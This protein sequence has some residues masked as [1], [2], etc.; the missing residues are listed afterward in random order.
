MKDKWFRW[1]KTTGTSQ[2]CTKPVETVSTSLVVYNAVTCSCSFVLHR[3]LHLK[4]LKPPN[5]SKTAMGALNS[6]IFQF[7]FWRVNYFLKNSCSNNWRQ[8]PIPI[9]WKKISRIRFPTYRLGL[10]D[11]QLFPWERPNHLLLPFASC[12]PISFLWPCF[13]HL[14]LRLFESKFQWVSISKKSAD[15]FLCFRNGLHL[16]CSWCPLTLTLLEEALF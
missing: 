2:W 13:L 3:T 6:E 4:I 12:M 10:R 8:S 5:V 11:L 16:Y 9:F 7:L 14:G 1:F 15:F